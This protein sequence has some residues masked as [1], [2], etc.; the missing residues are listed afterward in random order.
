MLRAA[1]GILGV[2]MALTNLQRLALI[3]RKF[4][5]LQLADLVWF[6]RL[7]CQNYK[8]NTRFM[9]EHPHIPVP[10]PMILYD[11]QGNCDLSG[12]YYSGMEHAREISRI[13]STERPN[14][15]LKILEWGCGPARVLQ[16]LNVI[17]EDIWELWGSDYNLRTITWCQKNMPVINFIHNGLEPPI[18]AENES[19][20]VIYCV[21]VFTH[22]SEERH[23]QWINEI[24]RLLKPGGLFI[25][26]FH[27]A[28]F[29]G[30]LSE[31]EQ[32]LFDSGNLVIRDKVREGKKDFAAYHC[33]SFVSRL[34]NIF[35]VH[36]K[37]TNISCFRQTVWTAS[38]SK[39]TS[40]SQML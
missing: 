21:S 20:D 16:H 29:K 3:L 14:S 5:L 6:F 24:F 36:K 31:E 27:G 17:N 34:L 1:S 23:Y 11:V 2:N 26:T 22:L 30:N 8:Q 25:G 15:D 35:E 39:M 28:E 13:I 19:F 40:D 12:F 9:R 33:D 4:H 7:Y 10:P 38:K 37:Y 18:A 32:C